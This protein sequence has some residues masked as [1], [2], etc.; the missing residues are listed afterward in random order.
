[1]FYLTISP[2]ATA[3]EGG[4]GLLRKFMDIKIKRGAKV[5]DWMTERLR[6]A[7]DLVL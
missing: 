2:A 4:D 7:E 3:S 1:M 5:P 6:A